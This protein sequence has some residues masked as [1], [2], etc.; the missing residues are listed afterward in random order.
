MDYTEWL[1]YEMHFPNVPKRG[2]Q[3][4]RDSPTNGDYFLAQTENQNMT[5]DSGL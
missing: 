3:R 1:H 4:G 2:S 5:F